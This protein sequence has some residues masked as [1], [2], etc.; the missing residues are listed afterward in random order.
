[1]RLSGAD[2]CGDC[3]SLLDHGQRDCLACGSRVGW[4]GPLL[5]ELLPR[6]RESN[7]A[8]H[9]A[10]FEGATA[11][12]S[13]APSP[14]GK[15]Q[16]ERSRA[17]RTL[18]PMP[19]LR[20][21][22]ARVSTLLVLVFLG[23]GVLLGGSSHVN[24]TL[25]RGPGRLGA[26]RRN[27]ELPP[28]KHVF[29]IMHFSQPYAAV[30]GPASPAWYISQT[31]ERHGVLL[32]RYDAVAHEQLADGLAILSG[33][34]PTA[35]TAANC[36]TYGDI[37]PATPSGHEQVLGTGCVYPWST[38][39]LPGQLIARRLTWRAD[40]QGPAEAGAQTAACGQPFRLLPLLGRLALVRRR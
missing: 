13:G 24:G 31:L 36:P 17:A 23:F 26:R 20:L 22:P 25:A 34:R 9:A 10:V 8:Q 11:G 16:R 12:G 4:R 7:G 35:E 32:V 33:Q 15:V 28:I 2:A 40:V 21:P 6:V 37:A 29:V 1:M 5:E 18:A 38:Q 19:A 39:T 27:S 30:F 14:A 3:G